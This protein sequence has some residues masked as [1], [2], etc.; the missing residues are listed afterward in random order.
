MAVFLAFTCRPSG[1][2]CYSSGAT[3]SDGVGQMLLSTR[4]RFAVSG[5]VERAGQAV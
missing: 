2:S 1:S 5:D 4:D 3:M